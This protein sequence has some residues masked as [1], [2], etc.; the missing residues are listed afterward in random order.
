M[1]K[2]SPWVS[3]LLSGALLGVPGVAS[4]DELAPRAAESLQIT[5]LTEGLVFPTAIDFLPNGELVIAEKQGRVLVR[6]P[7]GETV[8]AGQLDVDD[9]TEKGLLNV[10]HHPAFSTNRTLIFF[11]SSAKASEQDK[12]KISLIR[13]GEDDH[14]EL[15]SEKVLLQ[16]L[17]GPDEH[18]MGGGLAIDRSGNLLVG[19]GDTGCR[20]HRLPE[21]PYTPTNFFGTCLTNG[22][23]KVLRVGLDGSIPADNPLFSETS[24]TACGEKC[25]DDVFT[26][27]KAP[28]RKDI[29]VWGV[30]N[31]WRLWTDPKTGN[32]WLGDVGDIGNEEIDVIPPAGGKHYGWPFREGGQGHPPSECRKVSPDAGDCVDPAYYCRHDD[33]PG[34]A[35]A[36]CKS[37]NGGLIL[38]DCRWPAEFRGKY[39]FGDNANGK[40]WT[41]EPTP[42]R[43]SVVPGSRKDVG[44]VNGFLVDFD[45]GPDGALYA[46][47]MRIPPEE[48]K[49]VRLAPKVFGSCDAPVPP[50]APVVN[51]P[52]PEVHPAN[53]GMS[54]RKKFFG[55]VALIALATAATLVI[56]QSRE[57]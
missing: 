31:P 32:V 28:P 41:L 5:T 10:I 18:E 12:H 42:A 25:G 36:G 6:K 15:A 57:S 53:A 1:T 23:G 38:D 14:L 39:F 45:L 35:D 33:A 56:T 26:A 30:R 3:F 51:S 13:L 37:I 20:A 4:A 29:W 11:Y 44:Q 34:T 52:P 7:S 49:I 2:L 54:L 21:P 50:A 55:L 17:R 27:P 40:I 48:S 43:D 24:V 46:A 16:G 47:V 19:V 22:N 8:T 9:K